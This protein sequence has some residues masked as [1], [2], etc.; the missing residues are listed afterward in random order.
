MKDDIFI[1]Q[2]DYAK[3]ITE[4]FDLKENKRCM[5]IRREKENLLLDPQLYRSLVVS[6]IYLTITR[7]NNI[8]TVG[9]ISSFMQSPRKPQFEV[10]K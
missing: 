7:P 2:V 9:V 10:V 6:L 4:R 3:K 1:S 8:F 5:K